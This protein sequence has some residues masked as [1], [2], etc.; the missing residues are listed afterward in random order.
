MNNYHRIGLAY[1]CKQ[2]DCN[3]I[4]LKYVHEYT[5][6]DIELIGKTVHNRTKLRNFHS[7]VNSYH[8]VH[9]KKARIRGLKAFEDVNRS[10]TRDDGILDL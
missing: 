5:S 10:L 3:P 2:L 6:A 1:L 4:Q 7:N 9:P 8:Q